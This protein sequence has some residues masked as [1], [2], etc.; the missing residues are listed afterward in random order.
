MQRNGGDQREAWS[1]RIV[2]LKGDAGRS[3]EISGRAGPFSSQSAATGGLPCRD[4][5]LAA[6]ALSGGNAGKQVGVGRAGFGNEFDAQS[7][8]PAAA[9]VTPLNGAIRTKPMT[10]T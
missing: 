5:P 1:G 9:A 6:D 2:G 3:V 4:Q 10:L 7:S 8:D